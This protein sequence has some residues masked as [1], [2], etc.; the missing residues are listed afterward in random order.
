MAF[1]SLWPSGEVANSCM[2][3]SI[4]DSA[5]DN[6]SGSFYRSGWLRASCEGAGIAVISPN[7]ART[8]EEHLIFTRKS[9]QPPHGC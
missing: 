4:A 6:F 5:A 1:D 3:M 8:A 7:R 9:V 2:R